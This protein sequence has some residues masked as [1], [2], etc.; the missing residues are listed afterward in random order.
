MS[1]FGW[2]R[3]GNLKQRS[4][5]TSLLQGCVSC[6]V[7]LFA[8]LAIGASSPAGAI[9]EKPLIEPVLTLPPKGTKVDVIADRISIDP[10]SKNAVATGTVKMV[11]GPFTL[12]ATRV[13]Y[14]IKT[15]AFKAN[16][17]VEVREPNGNVLRADTMALADKFKT[18]FAEHV[19]ALLTNNVTITAQYAQRF[20][21]E[22]TVYEHA[23]YTACKDCTT[24]SGHALWQIVA[25]RATHDNITHDI[26]YVN[27][28]LQVNGVTIAA[29]PYF[30][31]PDP[32]V[33]RRSG[34]LLPDV[35]IGDVY[36]VGVA[37]TYFWALAP[38]Y[39]LTFRPLLTTRQGPV[40]DVEWRQALANGKYN[41]R[42]MGVHQFTS[43]PAYDDQTWRGAVETQGSFAINKNWNWGW[44]GIFASDRTFLNH[45]GYD[46][47]EI[48][49]N[50]V[51]ATGLWDEDY[52]S[53]QLLNFQSL[54]TYV[55][56]S[57]MPYAMPYVT[58]EHVFRDIGIGGDIDLNWS[59]YSLHRDANSTPYSTVNHG[60]D[61]TR[62]SIDLG[63]KTQMT[64][65]AGVVVS[66]FA[67][68]RNEI[69]ITD[70]VPGA[71]STSETTGQ[72]LPSAGVDVRMPFIASYEYGQSIIS[73]VFQFISAANQNNVNNW[74][75]EDAITLNFDHTSLFLS[76]R[77]TGL[78]RYEGG[79]R[80]NI[81]LTYAYYDVNGGFARASI[82]ESVHIA[83]QN[84]FVAG[85]GLSG[86]NSDV[87][88][89]IVFQPSDIMSLSYE[90]RMLNDFSALD[91]QEALASLTFDR[92]SA[93]LGYLYIAAE[94]NY[95]RII[96]ENW[97][98]GS[99]KVDLKDGWSVFG[100]LT[101]D[102]GYSQVTAKTLGLEFDCE[103]M[104][105]KLAYTGTSDPYYGTAEDKVMMSV[106]FATLGK[107]AVTTS[108]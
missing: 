38:D 57:D 14:N 45:Y 31:H 4:G 30:T 72:F 63:W 65:D 105:F 95:G 26:Y 32:S 46:E 80:A 85:S 25:D 20:D 36:G 70:N 51:H 93:N 50:D 48:A 101:Y 67:H 108:F 55:N 107:A 44:N 74:G 81:G 90:A 92:I 89:N 66:P 3:L 37:P 40:A 27:P 104:N 76:D 1:C 62:G 28:K 60:T 53:A 21:G 61:Q 19:Q 35:K 91:R 59:A 56:S 99:A 12:T 41:I 9:T 54:T 49:Y 34:W 102:V 84:S 69:Y 7:V 18:G 103:C 71:S 13:E 2:W 17:S 52:V 78:D 94:P 97:V 22:I 29:S 23:T 106:E 8:L 5:I 96:A 88:A 33:K 10:R 86:E 87:V 24:R 16:G 68:L 73:P 11:Y 79:T 47:R 64:T 42:A 15:G 82:G 75:N 83:G 77:F 6:G 98:Q 39:D 58:G 43:L 100:G